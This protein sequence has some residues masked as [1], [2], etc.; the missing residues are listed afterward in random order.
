MPAFLF[1]CMGNICRSPMAHALAVHRRIPGCEFD[2]AGTHAGGR[3]EPMDPRA[4]AALKRRGVMLHPK[5]RSRRFETRDF[6]RFDLVL[7]MDRANLA[8][9]QVLC[10]PEHRNKVRLFMDLGDGTAGT[11]VP[12]PYYGGAEGFERV[13][14]MCEVGI[15]GLTARLLRNAM[16]GLTAADRGP[17]DVLQSP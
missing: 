3:A 12:D 13:L 4:A 10:A 5:A 6:E 16:S 11:E 15:D 17:V 7:A 2:S 9:L 14:D 8:A 1:V